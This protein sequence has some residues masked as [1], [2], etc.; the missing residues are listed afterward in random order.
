MKNLVVDPILNA[1]LGDIFADLDTDA[2]D[3]LQKFLE[4]SQ[5]AGAS[6]QDGFAM[7]EALQASASDGVFASRF[8]RFEKKPP[9]HVDEDA[10]VLTDDA[11]LEKSATSAHARKLF[12]LRTWLRKSLAHGET[13]EDL[14]ANAEQYDMEEAL[15]IREAAA[16][17]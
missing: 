11:L 10:E 1:A 15:A 5:I 16:G 2:A 14:I 8:D 6:G 12:N 4:A 17:L 7:A 13:L 3:P 9:A